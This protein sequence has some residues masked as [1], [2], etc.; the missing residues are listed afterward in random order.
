M[1]GG[2]GRAAVLAAEGPGA[3]GAKSP[4]RRDRCLLTVAPCALA[5]PGRA[6]LRLPELKGPRAGS[7]AA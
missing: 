3:L 7:E 1:A 5:S 6:R 2:R 4:G